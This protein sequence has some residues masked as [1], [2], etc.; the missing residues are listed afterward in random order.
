MLITFQRQQVEV[1][2]YPLPDSNRLQD[3]NLQDEAGEE[4][5]PQS[6]DEEEDDLC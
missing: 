5:K 4:A 6:P 2:T 3:L 1:E